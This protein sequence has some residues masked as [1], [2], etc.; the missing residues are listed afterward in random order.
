MSF[1]TPALT[2]G[3]LLIA[4]PIILHLVMRRQPT[5][6]LFP[7]LRFVRN[8]RS[9]NQ[10][11][12]RL[13]HW[14]LLALRCV[15]IAL[16]AFALA[17][18]VLKG[19][20]LKGGETGLVSAAIVVDNS[21]RMQYRVQ[22]ESRLD[23]AKQLASWLVDQLPSDSRVGVLASAGSGGKRLSERDA[24][25]VRVD[26]LDVSYRERPLED[27][28]GDAVDL[29]AEREG[30][31]HELYVFTDL[32]AAAWSDPTRQ[33]IAAHLDR[34]KG[35]NLMVVDVGARRPTNRG[36]GPPKLPGS[37]LA[38]GQPL[39]I[40]APIYTAAS[41]TAAGDGKPVV[42]E[43][44]MQAD[45]KPKK[46]AETLVEL[47][48][49]EEQTAR[50]TIASLEEDVY[51]GYV[52]LADG[53]AL[54]A[55]NTR[56][57]TIEIEPP[58]PVLLVGIDAA[59][60]LFVDQALAP[61][62]PTGAVPSEYET[63]RIE[64]SELASA[65]LGDYRTVWLLDPPPLE[66]RILRRLD[67]YARG[68]GSVAIALGRRAAS[69]SF[70]RP[71]P[72]ALLAGRLKWKSRDA[73]YLRPASY[74]HPALVGLADFA[75][76]I[77]WGEFPVFA[78]WAFDTLSEESAVI[79]PFANRDP[80]I[81]ER[82]VGAGRVVTIAT[83]F[84][85][86]LSNDP[87]NTLPTGQDPWPFLALTKNLA[88]YLSGVTNRRYNY[89]AGEAAILPT[90]PGAALGGYVLQLPSGESIRNSQ[91]ALGEIVVGTTDLPGNYRLRAGG[92]G[93]GNNAGRLDTGFS[94]NAGDDIG[95]LA[96][97]DF[98]QIAE[99][100]GED[101]VAL[102][103]GQ[104][105]LERKVDVGRVGREMYPWLMALVAIALGAEHL[106]SNRFYKE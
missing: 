77:P 74:E 34:L 52:R 90:P 66:D 40:E 7:A 28:V 105:Q 32:S 4:L 33:A 39:T 95:K 46:R 3:A 22:N 49:G 84:S 87:W 106:V 100:L 45:G 12:L 35:V 36:L 53:D 70:N 27:A 60:T 38:V 50:F 9:S 63:R 89:A 91:P 71:G 65:E 92:Q 103:R 41:D 44:W 68:G 55:D 86:S 14:I 99:S 97:I 23:A 30:D 57:F 67:D 78:Y 96:R 64:Y 62:D 88:D 15:A 16:L 98:A 73:T 25:L 19:S 80:A 17:R 31:R 83:S 10:T 82:K 11:R 8:R 85:D 75:A 24:A 37:V 29:L 81:I 6:L 47:T 94:A 1:L 104:S 43:L 21:P 59:A 54:E 2:A 5:H 72:Q 51:Q 102:A 13:R 69:S 58:R 18:P 20:G 93:E 56:Y 42:A 79:A 48:P 26:R 76:A 101:R 61:L